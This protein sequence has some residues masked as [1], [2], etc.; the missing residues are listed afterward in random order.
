MTWGT[1]HAWLPGLSVANGTR[2]GIGLNANI[3]FPLRPN[4]ERNR[5]PSAQLDTLPPRGVAA[6]LVVIAGHEPIEADNLACPCRCASRL[7]YRGPLR[8]YVTRPGC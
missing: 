1:R 3:R 7:S 4:L 6:R 5:W 2:G 8:D